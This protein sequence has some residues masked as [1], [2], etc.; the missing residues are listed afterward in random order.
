M[1][2]LPDEGTRQSDDDVEKGETEI[3]EGPIKRRNRERPKGTKNDIMKVRSF[4]EKE[5]RRAASARVKR[6]DTIR[7]RECTM[8]IM[9]KEIP[10]NVRQAR[11]SK[12]WENWKEAMNEEMNSKFK[13]HV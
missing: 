12:N 3:Q 6:S 11:K 2:A 5:E 9:D 10:K 13:H 1:R 4:L 8:V 7:N